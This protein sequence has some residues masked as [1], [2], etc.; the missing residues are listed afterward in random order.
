MV[1]RDLRGQFAGQFFGAF[2]IFGHPII[3]FCVYIFIFAVI[4]KTKIDRSIDLPRDYTTYILVG[5]VP[6]LFIQQSLV[7]AS[8]SLVAQANLVKQ[9]V[10][11]IEVLPFCA[12]LI[13]LIPLLVGLVV[14]AVYTLLTQGMLPWTY[15][16]L[17][18]V[19]ALSI[20]LMTGIGFILAAATP[21][22][23]DIKDVI[24]VATIVGVYVVPAF[25]LPQWVPEKLRFLIY[26]N[27]FSY[28][29]WVYQDT[30]YFGRVAHPWSWLFFA[31]GS[32]TALTLGY[33]AF[34]SVR[35][36]IADVL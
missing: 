18:L 17:P 35:I 31:V 16:L 23:R 2:W 22:F 25:Y 27:P 28:V 12:V 29:I 34:R 9:V 30:L 5:L 1:R 7:R 33:R 3:Q 8:I 4:F 21:F 15:V 36:F 11:P 26:L 20:S 24:Q 6:W 19:V 32:I 10:F 14:I 13:S